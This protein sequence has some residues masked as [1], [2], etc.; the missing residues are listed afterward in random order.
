MNQE[1]RLRFPKYHKPVNEIIAT[2]KGIQTL[3]LYFLG[4]VCPRNR[5][6]ITCQLN[7]KPLSLRRKYLFRLILVF[8]TSNI[9]HKRKYR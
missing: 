3:K 7:I 1:A 4:P 5:P 6:N 2:I 9:K 8:C